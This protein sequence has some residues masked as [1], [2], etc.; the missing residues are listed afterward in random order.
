MSECLST[1]T[2]IMGLT[3][4]PPISTKDQDTPVYS[5]SILPTELLI[6]IFIFAVRGN[7]DTLAA[8][9]LS[10]VCHLWRDTIDI[11]PRIWQ[12]VTV[13]DTGHSDK[14]IDAQAQLWV[15]RSFPLQFSLEL[16]LTDFQRLLSIL[17]SYLCHL[18]RWRLCK[19]EYENRIFLISMP[20][21][22]RKRRPLLRHLELQ[23]REPFDDVNNSDGGNDESIFYSDGA[24]YISMHIP[25]SQLPSSIPFRTLG[26]S[27]LDIT[28]ASLDHA[29]SSP[30][31]LAFLRSCP[32]LETFAYH[33]SSFAEDILPV[34]PPIIV[35]P[36][37]EKLLLHTVCNQRA[38]L[39]S[40]CAPLLRE[41]RLKH[42]NVDYPL[43]AYHAVEPGDSD[44]EAADF[45]QSPSSDHHTGMGLRAFLTR[46]RPPL[47]VLDMCFV[48]MRTKDFR[49]MFERLPRLRYFSI[50]GSDMSD[51]VIALFAPFRVYRSPTV[52]PGA[53]PSTALAELE[54]RYAVRL[55]RLAILK[56]FSCQQCSGESMV[57][58]ITRRVRF[59]DSAMP[60]NSLVHVVIANCQSFTTRNGQD[61]EWELGHRLHWSL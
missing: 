41:L 46:S 1:A 21:L 26:F 58:A 14:F 2:T 53:S 56:L 16:H 7:P 43:P 55:P 42:M 8:L 3:P 36:H 5:T 51:K 18:D 52:S 31:L 57:D 27:S 38:I 45:S 39:S 9:T 35:L 47:E 54:P 59:M 10:K 48:D 28:E 34:S 29:V 22:A 50:E 61:L 20:L 30:D 60:N 25:I 15:Q 13:R 6:E 4:T 12:H 33:G 24:P 23:L 40:L 37:L 19:I 49:W 17:S 32:M 11:S 44:D